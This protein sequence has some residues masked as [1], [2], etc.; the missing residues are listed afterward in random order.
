[1]LRPSNAPRWVPCPASP[2]LESQFPET[3]SEDAKEGTTAHWLA[4]QVLAGHHQIDELVDRMA[5]N[6]VIC[7]GEMIEHVQTYIDTVC[8]VTATPVV[9][10]PLLPWHPAI[11]PGTPDALFVQDSHGY[12]WD[13]KYG[14]SIVEASSHQLAC[15][16][17]GLA[18]KHEWK[19]SSVTVTIVQPR[20]YHIDGRVRSVTYNQHQ[21]ADMYQRITNA[22]EATQQPGA[23]ATTGSHCKYCTALHACESARRAALNAVDVSLAGQRVDIESHALAQ[24]LHTLRRAKEAIE[25]RLDAMESHA[26]ATIDAGKIV[27]GW[28]LQRAYGQRKWLD[29]AIATL[30][31]LTG[32][33]LT[34]DKP[35]TPAAVEKA[36]VDKT[37][38]KQ[39]TTTPETGRK[40]VPVDGSTKANEVFQ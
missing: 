7:T 37:L 2:S 11:D 31:A 5:P 16:A 20:P 39:F 12:I 24:E 33:K 36:G 32:R 3:E 1:M 9:E 21:Y 40:L 38:V 28:S 15:Y 10:K 4:A 22:A 6:G 8:S 27:P 29:G 19:L 34:E 26:V 23:L 18:A 25:K 30:A 35:M 17:L 14:Y 13:F